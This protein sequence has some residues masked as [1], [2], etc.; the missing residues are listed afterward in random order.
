VGGLAVAIRLVGL[1]AYRRPVLANDTQSY[2]DLAHRLASLHLAGY[3][4]ARTPGYPAILLVLGYSSVGAWILHAIVGVVATLVVYRLVRRIGGAPRTALVATLLYALD[5]EVLAVERMV[6]TETIASFLVLV[7]ASMAVAIADSERESG[8]LAGLL[9]LILC[10]LCLVRP[11]ALA[12]TAYLAAAVV[13][14]RC[15]RRRRRARPWLRTAVRYGATILAA[16]LLALAGWAAVNSA[17]IGVTS[18]STVIGHNMIDHVAAYVHVE[19][20]ANHAITSAFVAARARREA[21]TTNL[22]N[23]SYDAEPYMEQSSHL[24]AAHVSVRLLSIALGVVSR[25]PLAYIA[26]SLKQWPRFFVPPN[27]AYQFTGGPGSALIHLVWKLERALK[28]LIAAA[29]LLLCLAEVV[30]R[31]RGRSGVLNLPAALLAGAVFVGSVPAVFFAFG[32]TGRYGYVYYP[33]VLAVSFAAGEPLLRAL[34]ARQARIRGGP[35]PSGV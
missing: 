22:A 14:T 32:E 10:C 21:H 13:L 28:L 26:S 9:G 18:V 33:L 24:G 19:R 4:G 16:P 15:L 35:H 29:F 31:L 5:M 2:L 1:L 6:A 25:H 27:Y 30:C 12:F 11:D 23:L 3:S 34:M 17:T 7:A 20:G 8:M